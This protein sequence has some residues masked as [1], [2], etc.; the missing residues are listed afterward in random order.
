METTHRLPSIKEI[1]KEGS[2]CHA[3]ETA[4]DVPRCDINKCEVHP[5]YEFYPEKASVG[6]F[7][8]F[9][10]R[11]HLESIIGEIDPTT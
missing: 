10:C 4:E 6:D 8:Y 1:G 11:E 5:E 9:L 3:P 7:W 2:Y